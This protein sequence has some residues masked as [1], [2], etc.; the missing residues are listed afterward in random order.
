MFGFARAFFHHTGSDGCSRSLFLRTILSES[1]F[2]PRRS[3]STTSRTGK[4]L[5]RAQRT[6]ACARRMLVGDRRGTSAIELAM[7]MPVFIA[8]VVATIEFGRALETW[9][10]MNRA[11]SQT[12]RIVNI[13]ASKTT[14]EVASALEKI[15]ADYAE[16]GLSVSVTSVSV[17]GVSHLRISATLPFHVNIPFTPLP[18]FNLEVDT[19]APLVSPMK[20]ASS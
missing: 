4:V 5:A 19:L 9:S 1:R 15:L 2:S 13:D 10:N 3:R 12:V 14:A 18:A 11:V 6:V 17:A 20:A 16:D 7:V 8:I